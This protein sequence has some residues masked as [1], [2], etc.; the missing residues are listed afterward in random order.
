MM[1]LPQN[2]RQLLL[3][4]CYKLCARNQVPNVCLTSPCESR[5]GHKSSLAGHIERNCIG[6]CAR[7]SVDSA[8]ITGD[9]LVFPYREIKKHRRRPYLSRA[10]GES[11]R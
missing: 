1:Q 3:V 5:G 6:S 8:T 11:V 7:S 10:Q 9:E 4:C 2:S